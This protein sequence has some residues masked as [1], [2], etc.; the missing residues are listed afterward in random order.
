MNF[1]ARVPTAPEF[2]KNVLVLDA[3][4][5]VERIVEELRQQVFGE[6]GRR[7][8]VV[9]LSGGIDSSVVAALCVRAFGNRQGPGRLHARAPFVGRLA[10]TRPQLRGTARHRH[11]AG[12]HSIRRSR[13][14]AAI[15]GRSKRSGP[16]F[17]NMATAGNASW[18]SR[19]S[20]R[21]NGLNVTRLTVQ[22]PRRRAPAPSRLSVGRLSA[23]RRRDQLQA[24]RRAR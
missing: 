14:S 13:G 12:R 15:A 16:S 20:S 1:A 21:A 19:R 6:L 3:A 10:A 11:R 24:A 4:A 17:P 8:A 18:C 2:G 5:E 22:S 7:G 9:G 23:A